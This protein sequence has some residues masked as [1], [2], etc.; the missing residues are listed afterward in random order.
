MIILVICLKNKSEC[1]N[2]H[3]KQIIENLSRN[4]LPAILVLNKIDLVNREKL[5]ET[6]AEY[7]I[8]SQVHSL[9]KDPA[10]RRN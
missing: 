7:S 8:S 3:I 9:Q 1:I 5:A 10:E 2:Y 4:E 6:I